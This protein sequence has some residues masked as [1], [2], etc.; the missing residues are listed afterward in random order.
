MKILDEQEAEEREDQGGRDGCA[1]Q[2][3]TNDQKAPLPDG[4]ELL[5]NAKG[6]EA[7]ES[8]GLYGGAHS[9]HRRKDQ[10]R[11]NQRHGEYKG[12]RG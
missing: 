1:D 9:K 11:G 8:A 6:L 2:A 4:A 7:R 3:S 12:H 5:A 10:Y